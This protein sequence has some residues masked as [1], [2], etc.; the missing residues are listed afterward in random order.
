MRPLYHEINSPLEIFSKTNSPLPPH[1][2]KYLECIYVTEGSLML[3]LGA[4]WF[5]MQPGDLAVLFPD[6][7][8][9][10]QVDTGAPSQAVYV[11]GAPAMAGSFAEILQKSYPHSPVIRRQAVHP[12]IPFALHTLLASDQ[13]PYFFDLRQ[14]YFQVLLARALPVCELHDKKE[15]EFPELAWQVVSYI[16]EHFM[17]EL[18]LTGMAHALCASPYALSRIFSGML[19]TNFNQ[20]LNEIRLDYASHLLRTTDRA[21]TDIFMD[22]GFSSQTT[23]NRAFRAKYQLSPRDYRRRNQG[24]DSRKRQFLPEADDFIHE[25]TSFQADSPW[26]LA[27][28]R[29]L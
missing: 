21:I 4:D 23:F 9:Q 19:H 29:F 17:E 11:L 13:D 1:L 16:S 28:G 7:I 14:A 6:M 5:K 18:S 27:K 3:G 10:F 22:S 15:L 24:T 20:Y 26:K 25:K 2:H 8:H 12:D